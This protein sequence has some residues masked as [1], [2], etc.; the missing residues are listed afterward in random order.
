[1]RAVAE[2]MRQI[3]VDA[4]DRGPA[5]DDD[6]IMLGIQFI[7]ALGEFGAQSR[8][9]SPWPSRSRAFGAVTAIRGRTVGSSL[10][11][12]SAWCLAKSRARSVIGCTSP[13]RP[14]PM[15]VVAGPDPRGVVAIMGA[16]SAGA[17]HPPAA[18]IMQTPVAATGRHLAGVPR[19]S[20]SR[21]DLP[22]R[23]QHQFPSWRRRGVGRATT[24]AVVLSISY[25]IVV[26]M[27]FSFS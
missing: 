18:Y 22:D 14:A 1:V 2:Q 15:L 10:A 3:G 5:G 8:S 16:L 24:R 19:L 4:A 23:H 21:A 6:R 9:S 17:E 13:R 20:C 25:I 12:A 11:R 7:A 27:I 26:D